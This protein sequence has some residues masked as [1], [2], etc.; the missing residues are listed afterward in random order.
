MNSEI[1]IYIAGAWDENAKEIDF[2]KE[3]LEKSGIKWHDVHEDTQSRDSSYCCSIKE[4]LSKRM[5]WCDVFILVVGEKTKEVTKGKCMYCSNYN[6][7][8]Y[9]CMSNKPMVNKSFIEFECD[10][11]TN[12]YVKGKI[13]VLVLYSGVVNR[14]L[15][16]DSLKS[17]GIHE[18]MKINGKNDFNKV[19]SCIYNV[20]ND[21]SNLSM[22]Y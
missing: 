17:I 5:E 6:I 21:I 11:A 22:I 19:F 14:E 8:G 1:N 9:L 18:S 10:K 2:L 12:L 7:D 15:C 16:P 13:K 4:S 20:I 3:V